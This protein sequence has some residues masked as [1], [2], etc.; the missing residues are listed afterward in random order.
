MR[1]PINEGRGLRVAAK[2]RR[3]APQGEQQL[4]HQIVAVRPLGKAPGDVVQDGRVIGQPAF[5]K[6]VLRGGVQSESW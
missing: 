4:L 2:R 5:E 3:R 6:G 1:H